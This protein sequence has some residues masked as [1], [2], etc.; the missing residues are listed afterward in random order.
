MTLAFILIS[1]APR[2]EHEVY[3][4][5]L[6]IPEIIELHPLFG[7]YDLIARVE[8]PDLDTLAHTVVDKIRKIEGITDTK[9]L[10]GSK[11]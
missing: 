4:E 3:N 2:K 10:T 8:V 5:L 7:D 11:F 1:T 9:T 6:K